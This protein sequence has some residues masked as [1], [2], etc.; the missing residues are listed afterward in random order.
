MSSF[1]RKS[2]IILLK[3]SYL[4]IALLRHEEWKILTEEAL[5]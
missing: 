3:F 4:L 5:I 2:L 1:V